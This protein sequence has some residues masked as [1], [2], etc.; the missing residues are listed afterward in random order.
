[1]EKMVQKL[2]VLHICA[3]P[4]VEFLD[5]ISPEDD[6]VLEEIAQRILIAEKNICTIH[7]TPAQEDSLQGLATNLREALREEFGGTSLS[8]KYLSNPPKRGPFGE[9]EIWLRPDARPVSVPPFQLSGERR[10]ALDLLVG[11]G[12]EQGK[13]EPG[14]GPWNTPVPQKV[15]HTYRLVQ[16]L[17]PQ[18]VATLKDGHPLPRIREMVHRQ[19]KNCL[20]TVLDLVDGF[21]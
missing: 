7:P 2:R 6:E 8:G 19:G 20:W 18:N 12:M 14:K 10:E 9:G 16:D 1:M 13:L 11:K 15:P 3:A 17:R 5:D 4:E 21:H